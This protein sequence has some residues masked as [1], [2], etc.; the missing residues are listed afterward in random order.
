MAHSLASGPSRTKLMSAAE[1]L[2]VLVSTT[3][4]STRLKSFPRACVRVCLTG[5]E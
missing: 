2:T 5:C 4:I 3:D 1:A